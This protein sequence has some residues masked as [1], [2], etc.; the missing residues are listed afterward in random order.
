MEVVRNE[1]EAATGLVCLDCTENILTRKCS[2][3]DL[4]LVNYKRQLHNMSV[5]FIK[6]SV[7]SVVMGAC[8]AHSIDYPISWTKPIDVPHTWDFKLGK[9]L[10]TQTENPEPLILEMIEFVKSFPN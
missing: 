8:E 9:K 10:A 4:D 1:Q 6:Y 2:L 7:C 3:D 5:S